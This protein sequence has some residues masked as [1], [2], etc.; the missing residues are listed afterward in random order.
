MPVRSIV[1]FVF[2]KDQ[3]RVAPLGLGGFIIPCCCPTLLPH[4]FA[5]HFPRMRKVWEIQTSDD[6][7]DADV[8]RG[9]RD[10]L[11]GGSERGREGGATATDDD[12]GRREGVAGYG[13]PRFLVPSLKTLPLA[14][15]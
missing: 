8:E 3:S 6:E 10:T 5:P 15:V 7:R 4:T 11:K 13:T 14:P 12:G 9:E 2:H 1:S